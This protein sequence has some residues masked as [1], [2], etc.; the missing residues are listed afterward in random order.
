MKLNRTTVA[1]ITLGAIALGLLTGCTTSAPQA[2]ESPSPTPTPTETARG[3]VA[4]PESEEEAIE[5]ADAVLTEWFETR[6]AVNATAG[7]ALDT[8]PLEELST[9]RALEFSVNDATQ[10]STGPILNVDE[11]N[12]EGPGTSEGAMTFETRNAY[13][14]EWEGIENGLVTINA[15]QDA[16]DYQVYASDGSEAMMHPD[17]RQLFDYQVVYDADREAWLVSDLISLGQTC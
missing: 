9:G 1:S 15:C 6:G 13:G 16:S 7:T 8:A 10:I 3:P 12:V 2:T 17:P 5:Q 4:P 14:Q 11:V